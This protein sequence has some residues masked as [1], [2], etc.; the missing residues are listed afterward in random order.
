MGDLGLLWMV[1]VVP[2]VYLDATG[3]GIQCCLVSR[4]GSLPIELMCQQV[5][6]VA[7]TYELLWK[8][9]T[10]ISNGGWDIDMRFLNEIV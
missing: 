4:G 1:L 10:S 7:G 8:S 6:V 9:M 5:S 3:P 2:G